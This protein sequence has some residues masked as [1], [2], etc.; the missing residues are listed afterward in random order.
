MDLEF[1]IS[2]VLTVGALHQA[3]SAALRI[4]ASLWHDELALLLKPM[5]VV[6]IGGPTSKMLCICVYYLHALIFGTFLLEFLIFCQ[7][8]QI[9]FV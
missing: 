5:L 8:L 6:N 1:W 7:S 2:Q 4:A 3:D 9:N